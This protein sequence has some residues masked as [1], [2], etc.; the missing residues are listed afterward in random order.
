[1]VTINHKRGDTFE[2][3]CSA[4]L[5]F[6]ES[7]TATAAQIRRNGELVNQLTVTVGTPTL[8]EYKYTISATAAQT[9]LWVIGSHLV[10]IQYTIGAKVASTETFAVLVIEDITR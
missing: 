4:P 1:M 10:D 2:L 3:S 7:L 5:A 9:A 8:T 6:G